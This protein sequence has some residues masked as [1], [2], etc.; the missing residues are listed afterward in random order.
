MVSCCCCSF[1]THHPRA[2]QRDGAL[3]MMKSAGGDTTNNAREEV[4]KAIEDIYRKKNPSKL[5]EIDSL[6]T[7]YRGKEAQLLDAIKKKYGQIA[8]TK[9]SS[10]TWKFVLKNFD[11]NNDKITNKHIRASLAVVHAEL[12]SLADSIG[13][14]CK[15]IVGK[16]GQH[17]LVVQSVA[18]G[19][20]LTSDDL[21]G[22]KPTIEKMRSLIHERYQYDRKAS[23]SKAPLL[24]DE[25]DR[26]SEEKR[27]DLLKKKRRDR[28]NHRR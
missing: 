15:E 5:D 7:K 6:M 8:S 17:K 21:D 22:I 18:D 16:A 14:E 2:C 25:H 23:K 20:G 27:L 9:N 3:S 1:D 13:G 24:S 12:Q 19:V 10:P 26:R 4:K 11:P 28:H